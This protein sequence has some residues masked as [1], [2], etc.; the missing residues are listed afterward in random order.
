[1]ESF[2]HPRS[3]GTSVNKRRNIFL[4]RPPPLPRYCSER[5][6]QIFKHE[7]IR[8]RHLHELCIRR[9]HRRVSGPHCSP[10]CSPRRLFPPPL[11]SLFLRFFLG[12]FSRNP[13]FLLRRLTNFYQPSSSGRSPCA[14]ESAYL[15]NGA[16]S[17]CPLALATTDHGMHPVL[18]NDDD[19][20]MGDDI[21]RDDKQ[22]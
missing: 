7:N 21:R 10:L 2:V 8:G 3:R 17:S 14:R 15:A 13:C 4:T 20:T 6:I 1:M 22:I 16:L 9:V 18:R 11:S 19:V 12:P 5:G